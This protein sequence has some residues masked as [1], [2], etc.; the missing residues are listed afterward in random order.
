MCLNF[1]ATTREIKGRLTLKQFF[2]DCKAALFR[3][4]KARKAETFGQEDRQHYNAQIIP[5]SCE[6]QLEQ[7]VIKRIRIITTVSKRSSFFLR[8]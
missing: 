4:R 2:I 6:L 8:R 1:K 5:L 7:F 3:S